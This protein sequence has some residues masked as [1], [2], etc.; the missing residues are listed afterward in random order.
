ME[1][2]RS[3]SLNRRTTS[4]PDPIP[5]KL[6]EIKDKKMLV[7]EVETGETK[8]LNV[9]KLKRRYS[10]KFFTLLLPKSVHSDLPSQAKKP[11]PRSDEL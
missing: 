4:S 3:S 6:D 1:A 7:Y 9:S 8:N 2:V 11:F 5:K 10:G